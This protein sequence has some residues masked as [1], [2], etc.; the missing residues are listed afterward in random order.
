ML[1]LFSIP[2]SFVGHIGVI[3]RNAIASWKLLHPAVEVIL[4]GEDKGTAEVAAEFSCRYLPEV[5]RNASGTPLVSGVFAAA[6][7]AAAYKTMVYVNADIIL[8]SDFIAAINRLPSTKSL[9][10]GERWDMD[11]TESIDFT[12]PEW[13]PALREEARLKGRAHGLTGIDYFLF[14]RGLFNPIPDLA[15]GRCYWDHWLLYQARN[16][17]AD[18]I[19]ASND[20]LAI[21]QN[22]NYGH[23]AASPDG[24]EI[25]TGR[26]AYENRMMVKSLLFHLGDA[27]KRMYSGQV[28]SYF[29]PNLA[30]A[31]NAFAFFCERH[32]NVWPVRQ[33]AVWFAR[34]FWDRGWRKQFSNI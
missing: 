20:V 4:V 10:C 11:I 9:L 28:K 29:R 1:T 2:K 25:F 31:A 12:Q 19:D 15:I 14:E 13:E 23:A 16:N 34:Q 17:G 6:E 7:Q 21:H 5:S 30:H 32:F 27:N 18:I 24:R 22:H 8:M 3:Q 33:M 26:E